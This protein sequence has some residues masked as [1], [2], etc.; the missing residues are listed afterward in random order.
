[1]DDKNGE[2][3]RVLHGTDSGAGEQT[4]TARTQGAGKEERLLLSTETGD[5]SELGRVRLH[6]ERAQV[7]VQRVQAGQVQVR[8]VVRERQETLPVTLTSE[9]LEII[10]NPEASGRVTMD[11][12]VLE[13]GRSYEVLLTEERAQVTKQVFALS[14][15]TVRKQVQTSTHQETVT[16]RREE[17]DVVD[18]Q[19]L[20]HVIEESASLLPDPERR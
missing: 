6:E 17:L 9:Y 8:K 15:V 20:A 14:E 11:G 10:V 16:L 1:M 18:A 5:L 4:A 12:Q 3:V 7:D 19:G 13:A 2:Q